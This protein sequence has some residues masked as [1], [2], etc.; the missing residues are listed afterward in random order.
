MIF[1]PSAFAELDNVA[2]RYMAGT[3]VVVNLLAADESEQRRMRDFLAGVVF[4]TGG[5]LESLS[6]G[7]IVLR[8]MAGLVTRRRLVNKMGP[9]WR[10]A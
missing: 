10:T 8:P 7:F 3:T 6:E 1:T 2:A 5:Q 9:G 4:A